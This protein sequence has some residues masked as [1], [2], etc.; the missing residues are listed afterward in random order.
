MQDW[1]DII[2]KLNIEYIPYFPNP[3]L[4]HQLF[5]TRCSS[6]KDKDI[7]AG[8]PKQLYTSNIIMNF[9]SFCESH[10]FRY[11]ILSDYEKYG[12]MYQEDIIENYDIH[13]SSVTDGFIALGKVVKRRLAERGIT[14]LYFYNT[15][16][17]MSRPYFKMMF[18]SGIK[19]FYLTQLKVDPGTLPEPIPSAAEPGMFD[20]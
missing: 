18:N 20:F 15:S 13:P 4:P 16:P 7:A 9:I 10:N 12:V 2:K 17:L 14:E 19:S 1:K 5:I 6:S 11:A 8:T 3:Q